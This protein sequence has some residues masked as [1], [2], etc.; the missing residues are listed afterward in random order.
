MGGGKGCSRK[1]LLEAERLLELVEEFEGIDAQV[2]ESVDARFTQG[3]F[4]FGPTPSVEFSTG[5][6]P[7]A[8]LPKSCMNRR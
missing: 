4:V 8:T 5:T 2:D 1:N 3:G 6:I 7:R